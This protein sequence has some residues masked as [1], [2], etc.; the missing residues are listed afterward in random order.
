MT[1]RQPDHLATP[2]TPVLSLTYDR[3]V[4]PNAVS[5]D[6]IGY[7]RKEKKVN[8]M[9]ILLDSLSLAAKTTPAVIWYRLHCPAS[10]EPY[11]AV[12]VLSRGTL[13]LWKFCYARIWADATGN[14]C[15]RKQDSSLVHH[16]SP[17]PALRAWFMSTQ[18]PCSLL[19]CLPD[20]RRAGTSKTAAV[21]LPLDGGWTECDRGLARL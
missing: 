21:P 14:I 18:V 13:P 10:I 4:L 15:V 2:V 7:R 12:A 3:W 19:A 16:P 9:P 20:G 17:L 1:V 5:N 6:S 8:K 11:L